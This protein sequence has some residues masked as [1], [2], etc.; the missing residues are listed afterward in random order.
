MELRHGGPCRRH[1][2]PWIICQTF[3]TP[4]LDDEQL[5]KDHA[6]TVGELCDACEQVVLKCT[7]N[8][9][10]PAVTKWKRAC[11]KRWRDRQVIQNAHTNHQIDDTLTKGSFTSDKWN[12]QMI[13]FGIVSESFHRS[14]S[15]VLA[16]SVPSTHK[17]AKRSYSLFDGRSNESQRRVIKAFALAAM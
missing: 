7:A 15:S 10:P 16:A 9:L 12:E 11:D 2:N 1:T 3:Q 5:P 14:A 6:E 17:M 8:A 13:L 4:C